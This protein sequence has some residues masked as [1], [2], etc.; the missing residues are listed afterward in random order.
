MAVGSFLPA[1]GLCHLLGED[2]D[3]AKLALGAP[4]AIAL[5]L[6]YRG[7]RPVR[8]WLVPSGGGKFLYLPVWLCGIL[9]AVYGVWQLLH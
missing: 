2:R 6:A 4:L 5:D 8:R 1:L 7:T 3:G 9:W